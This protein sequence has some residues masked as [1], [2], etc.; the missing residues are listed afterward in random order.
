MQVSRREGM[1]FWSFGALQERRRRVDGEVWSSGG[2][3]QACRNRGQPP[4]VWS[5]AANV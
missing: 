4:E 2:A 3:L 5:R 1:E